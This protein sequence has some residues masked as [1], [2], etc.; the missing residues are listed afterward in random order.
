MAACK[1]WP[2]TDLPAGYFEPFHSD[3]PTVLVSG[4]TDP[5]SPPSCGEEAK[6]FM[7]N[8]LHLV[9][10]GG[11]HTPEN[12]WTRSIRRELFRTGT[13]KGLDARCIANVRSLPFKLPRQPGAADSTP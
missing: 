3:V 10:H 2:K 5:A 9:V 13:T 6:S 1:D 4:A 8:A 7:P 12:D 11:G